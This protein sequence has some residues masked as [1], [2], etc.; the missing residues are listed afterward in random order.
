MDAIGTGLLR[1]V[2]YLLFRHQPVMGV[3][4]WFIVLLL[5]GS[6]AYVLV[7]WFHNKQP[8]ETGRHETDD[9]RCRV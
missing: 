8:R 1:A 6:V 2:G 5:I 7:G 9:A 3:V 4:A